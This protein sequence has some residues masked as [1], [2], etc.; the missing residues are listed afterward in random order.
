MVRPNVQGVASLKQGDEI[1][2]MFCRQCAR[3]QLA[4]LGPCEICG[5]LLT[6]EYQAIEQFPDD[7]NSL[8]AFGS[9]LP[10]D[11]SASARLPILRTP[12]Y[13]LPEYRGVRIFVKDET[14]MPTASCKDRIAAIVLPVMFEAGIRQF[15][16]G[17]TGNTARAYAH[18]LFAYPELS[19]TVYVPASIAWK[20]DFEVP[21]NMTILRNKGDYVVA[22]RLASSVGLAYGTHEGGFF[23]AARHEGAKTT[24]LELLMQLRAIGI[25]E[26]FVVQAIASGLG[27]VGAQRATEIGE[28]LD[29]KVPRLRLVGAQE[30]TCDPIV[31]TFGKGGSRAETIEIISDPHGRAQAL[32]L[33]DPSKSYR[34]VAEAVEHTGGTMVSVEAH[35][36]DAEMFAEGVHFGAAAA[37]A[38]AGARRMCRENQVHEGGCVVAIL[39]GATGR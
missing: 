31:R 38:L 37:V 12:L 29:E 32:L 2:N 35:E 3:G 6:Y 28:A 17:S 30:S 27:L 1:V 26:A 25:D 23:N 18:G 5:G 39:T 21:P 34:Y 22:N 33:G 15:V 14:Q 13:E 9:V 19:A 10:F 11:D 36:I 4:R 7:A 20:D 24:Y 8:R 16:F